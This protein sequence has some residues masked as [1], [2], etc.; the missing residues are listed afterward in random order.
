MARPKQHGRPCVRKPTLGRERVEWVQRVPRKHEE[1][2]MQSRVWQYTSV[3]P[4]SL[5]QD[6]TRKPG[7]R[8][9]RNAGLSLLYAGLNNK[10]PPPNTEI[11]S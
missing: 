6:G 5:Q 8:N 9:S 10:D 2:S 7:R 1:L 11:V 3:I 4:A